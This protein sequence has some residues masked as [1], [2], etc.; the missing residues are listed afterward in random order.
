M[1]YPEG[2]HRNDMAPIDALYECLDMWAR[3]AWS[4]ENAVSNLDEVMAHLNRMRY[5][6][7]AGFTGPWA[8]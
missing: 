7:P 5:A 2:T 8:G 4:D 1:K 3:G 6:P